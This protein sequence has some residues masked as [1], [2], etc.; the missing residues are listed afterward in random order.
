MK[1]KIACAVVIILTLSYNLSGQT[2]LSFENWS[3]KGF[4]EEPDN[5]QT[6]NVFAQVGGLVNCTKAAPHSGQYAVALS[7]GGFNNYQTFVAQTFA[8]DKKVGS[9]R[10]FYHYS[11]ASTD[12]ALVFVAFFKG[13][14]IYDSIIG[15]ATYFLQNNKTWTMAEENVVWLNSQ[16]PDSATI[17]FG[18]SRKQNS[19]TVFVDDVSLSDYKVNLIKSNL[20]NLILIYPNPVKGQLTVELKVSDG[21]TIKQISIV[22][23]L[24]KVVRQ[25]EGSFNKQEINV[26][27]LENGIYTVRVHTSKRQIVK[28]LNVV[29]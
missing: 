16:I 10:F 28:T 27:D 9:I 29:N 17:F 23:M 20:N 5:W 4:Y 7:A 22:D 1:Y 15:S 26:E 14:T 2:N 18:T 13:R 21:E 12:S 8:I 6:T 19:D 11:G 3:D 25:Q 24:G